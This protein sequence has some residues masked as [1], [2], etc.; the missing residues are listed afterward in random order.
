MNKGG[1]PHGD[2]TLR[3]LRQTGEPGC[4]QLPPLQADD[5]GWRNKQNFGKRIHPCDAASQLSQVLFH[6]ND[7]ISYEVIEM[8]L[9]SC[10]E[11]QHPMS[12]RA[13][14]CPHCGKFMPVEKMLLGF[15]LVLSIIV[16][17]SL[18]YV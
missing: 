13:D 5:S 4:L 2:S 9:I 3:R 14:V 12:S 18:V 17:M 6:L 1:R 8:A 11:C 10:S 16:F 7:V 15:K